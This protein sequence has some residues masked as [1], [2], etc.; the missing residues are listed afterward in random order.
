MIS[1]REVY[2]AS[3]YSLTITRFLNLYLYGVLDQHDALMV[4]IEQFLWK[5]FTACGRLSSVSRVA[6]ISAA[7]QPS[8]NATVPAPRMADA[9]L[10]G[11]KTHR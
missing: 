8:E 5:D 4:T 6:A 3:A 1:I 9:A 2:K 11:A 7:R 10:N